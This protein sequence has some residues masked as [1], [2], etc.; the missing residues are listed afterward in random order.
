V[1]RLLL[2]DNYDSFTYNLYQ[3]LSELG[4]TVE[5]RRNDALGPGDVTRLAPDG[6][7][8]SPG[9]C[10]PREAGVSND[11][12]E[13]FGADLPTL[14]VCLGLQCIAY[15]YGGQVVRAPELRH[16]KTSAIQHRGAGVFRDLPNPFEAVRYHSLVADEET[17]PDCLEVT[18]RT[19]SGLIMGLRHREFPVE[20]VQFH[21]ESILTEHG[22]QLLQNFLD[23]MGHSLHRAPLPEGEASRL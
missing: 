2:V 21:P 17:L 8:L 18:A 23:G 3:Y 14:G 5:V 15:T 7:V 9:P 13:R 19:D 11:L 22:K 10:T 16:G 4:A 6:L 1:T 12:I 20:G